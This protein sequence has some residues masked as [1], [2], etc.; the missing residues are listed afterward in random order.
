ML[1][2]LGGEAEVAAL[3]LSQVGFGT[4]AIAHYFGRGQRVTMITVLQFLV[5]YQLDVKKLADC[6]AGQG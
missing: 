5:Y 4:L 1:P 3:R 6:Q 2:L